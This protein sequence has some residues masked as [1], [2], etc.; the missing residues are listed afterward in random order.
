MEGGMISRSPVQSSIIKT[1]GY[2]AET[3]TLAVEFHSGR[4]YHYADVSQKKVDALL[5]SE[6]MGKHFGIHIKPH[7]TC[8]PQEV[9]E[10]KP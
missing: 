2:D 4:I 10:K 8:T 6:S 1:V 7:H 9:E 3:E 5:C